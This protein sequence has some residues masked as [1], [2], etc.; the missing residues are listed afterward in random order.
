MIDLH[1]HILNG[2]DDGAQTLE[3]SIAMASA[4]VAEGI[5]HILVT[6]HHKNGAYINE[7]DR[8][9]E[10]MAELQEELDSRGIELTLFPGQE[11]RINGELLEEID[12]RKIQF[13]DE[14]NQYL[15]IEFPT[16][17]VP[18][19]SENL[20]FELSKR[21]ITPVIVHPERNQIF[22]ENP[23]ALI[24][25]IEKGALAQLTAGSYLGKFGKKIQKVSK[26][27]VE[28]NLVHILAS[29]AH[30]VTSRGFRMKEAYEKLEKEFG[31]S[32]V[33]QF[34]QRT[35]DLVNGEIIIPDIPSKVKER[36][37]LGLF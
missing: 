26:Q 12:S 22:M 15:L 25:F 11:V 29:D 5:T 13:V 4:A 24:P 28:A 31:S 30:N 7:K 18:A 19:Y 1:C 16:M 23:N 2:I 36:K 3:D 37:I 20:F 35:K 21:N 33:S 14:D 6:P 17:T 9:L 8:I 27:M 34:K 10:K 32:K